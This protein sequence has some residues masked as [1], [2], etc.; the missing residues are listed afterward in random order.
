MSKQPALN[1][2]ILP[3]DVEIDDCIATILEV[4]KLVFET[5]QASIQVKCGDAISNIFHITYKDGKELRKK[6]EIEVNKLKYALFIY[7]KDEL[8]KRKIII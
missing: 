3:L 7:G 1:L 5:Y 4:S 6:L 2:Y 8:R